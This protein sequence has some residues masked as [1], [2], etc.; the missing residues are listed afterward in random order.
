M[1]RR[2]ENLDISIDIMKNDEVQSVISYAFGKLRENINKF[3]KSHVSRSFYVRVQPLIAH[4]KRS[5]ML[6]PESCKTLPTS[7]VI[8]TWS[9]A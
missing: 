6:N 5:E 3:S 9:S 1:M 8:S 7:L 2:Q 4:L